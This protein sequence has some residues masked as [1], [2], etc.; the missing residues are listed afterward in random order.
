MNL[1]L[2]KWRDSK[3]KS[4]HTFNKCL[5]CDT[6]LRLLNFD[7]VFYWQQ[8]SKTDNPTHKARSSFTNSKS[9]IT[10]IFLV[11][12]TLLRFTHHN[13]NLHEKTIQ[14]IL[15]PPSWTATTTIFRSLIITHP[16]GRKSWGR[17]VITSYVWYHSARPKKVTVI[18]RDTIINCCV[19]WLVCSGKFNF[20]WSAKFRNGYV[21]CV[22]RRF[23]WAREGRK[24]WI[25]KVRWSGRLGVTQVRWF[26][27]HVILLWFIASEMN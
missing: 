21:E 9:Q 12:H 11:K 14:F 5:L 3:I 4:F 18:I 7:T 23:L 6:F 22:N 19:R 25:L 1:K 20:V 17:R 24:E 8:I 2:M 13:N 26:V 27:V 16:Q 10:T 15:M